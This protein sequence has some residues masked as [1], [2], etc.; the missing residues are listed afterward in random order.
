LYPTKCVDQIHRAHDLRVH[1]GRHDH[2]ALL[3]YRDHHGCD[4]RDHLLSYRDHVH[5][6]YF[7]L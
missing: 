5:Q 6:K 7:F 2:H 1:H 3:S 4:R